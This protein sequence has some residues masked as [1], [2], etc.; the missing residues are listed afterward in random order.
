MGVV[1]VLMLDLSGTLLLL[2]VFY[3]AM[4]HVLSNV[5]LVEAAWSSLDER[6]NEWRNESADTSA[7][8]L[9]LL[10]SL[11][12]PW[13]GQYEDALRR[14]RSTCSKTSM[15]ACTALIVVLMAWWTQTALFAAEI[16][17]VVAAAAVQCWGMCAV[18][19]WRAARI[20]E[21]M[22]GQSQ[23]LLQIHQRAAFILNNMLTTV[24]PDSPT[25]VASWQLCKARWDM[26]YTVVKEYTDVNQQGFELLDIQLERKHCVAVVSVALPAIFRSVADKGVMLQALLCFKGVISLM[27]VLLGM[28]TA[29]A[30]GA[31]LELLRRNQ[32]HVLVAASSAAYLVLNPSCTLSQVG[33]ATLSFF[34]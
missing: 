34:V 22:T 17:A 18:L 9:K 2:L 28:S 31:Y 1:F 7:E 10:L 14:T 16:D 5:E 12:G 33:Q 21:K 19:C 6:F 8:A 26:E 3:A 13:R 32:A 20:S 4:K 29:F 11:D 15:R 24:S 23:H 27:L 25:Q 30:N